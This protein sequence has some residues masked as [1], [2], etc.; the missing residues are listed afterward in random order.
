MLYGLLVLS[1]L[2][3]GRPVE[4]RSVVFMRV[5]VLEFF[6]SKKWFV[7]IKGFYLE[8]PSINVSVFFDKI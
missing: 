3:V 4:F 7:W 6:V 2:P 1:Y 5:K 8:V